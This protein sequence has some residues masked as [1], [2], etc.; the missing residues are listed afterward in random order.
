MIN[1]RTFSH[2]HHKSARG[3]TSVCR[4]CEPS[5]S[6]TVELC[7]AGTNAIFALPFNKDISPPKFPNVSKPILSLAKPAYELRQSQD[8]KLQPISR[9]FFSDSYAISHMIKMPMCDQNQIY[10]F[11]K[12]NGVR[13]DNNEDQ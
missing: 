8:Q 11:I 13:L 3:T 7:I 9:P 6:V 5:G 4:L 2:G 12:I 1:G 10:F